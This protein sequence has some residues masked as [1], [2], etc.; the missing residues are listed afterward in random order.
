M[1]EEFRMPRIC[2]VGCLFHS[3]A[4]L[5]FAERFY[6]R[7]YSTMYGNQSFQGEIYNVLVTKIKLAVVFTA[8]FYYLLVTLT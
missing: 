6:S 3:A 7:H 2:A 4:N 5:G 1:A 8:Q